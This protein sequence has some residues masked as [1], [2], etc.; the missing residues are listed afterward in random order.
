MDI[1]EMQ[2]IMLYEAAF[3][4]RCY[5]LNQGARFESFIS[6][7]DPHMYWQLTARLFASAGYLCKTSRAQ[8]D[9][10]ANAALSAFVQE[11][12]IRTCCVACV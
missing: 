12:Q 11:A 9:V 7:K 2:L 3:D 10:E 4:E 8:C 6:H 1:N 5:N